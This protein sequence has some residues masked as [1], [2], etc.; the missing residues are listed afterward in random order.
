M[1]INTSADARTAHTDAG[2]TLGTILPSKQGRDAIHLAVECVQAGPKHLW[3]GE[4]VYRRKDGTYAGVNDEDKEKVVGIVDPFLS[5]DVEPGQWFWLVLMPRTIRS[6][7]HVWTHPD[8]DDAPVEAKVE[9]EHDPEKA[10]RALVLI[11]QPKAVAIEYIRQL[12]SG[13]DITFDELIE[14]AQSYVDHGEYLID[15]GKFE[16]ESIPSEFWGH[17]S[18]YTGVDVPQADQGSFLSCSC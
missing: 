2:D 4:R 12:A 3:A 11:G 9:T 17:Y 6:L 18:E 8:F 15:G 1:S 13:L 5:E 14:A 16:G 10:H 7:R